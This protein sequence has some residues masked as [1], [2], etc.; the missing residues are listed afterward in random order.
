MAFKL[1][2]VS[3]HTTFAYRSPPRSGNEINGLGETAWRPASHVFHNDGG[4]ALPW[5]GLDGLFGYVMHWKVAY[6]IARNIWSLRRATGPVAKRQRAVPE[7]AAMTAEILERAR[8]LGADLVGVTTIQ[9]HHVYVGHDVP[10][11]N[12]IAIGVEMDRGKMAGVPDDVSGGEVMRVYAEV[13][14]IVGRLSE[15]IRGMG[16]PARG[17]GNPNSGDLLHIPIA[18]DCGFGQLGKHGSLISREHGSNFRLGCVVTDLPLRAETTR[19]DIGVDDLCDRCNICVR[20]CPVDAIFDV[21]QMVRGVRKWY[22]DFDKCIYYFC[23]TSGCGICIEVCPWSETGA[24]PRLSE[25][26]LAK[27]ALRSAGSAPEPPTVGGH[28]PRP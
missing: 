28:T 4:D 5:D 6:W 9:P 15:E 16:W 21:K 3:G 8:A 12:A 19:V 23:E 26:L 7:P 1:R 25:R 18:I 13:G 17:Y 20:S 22:V 2:A 24:G 11:E 27:R 10:Y 14:R